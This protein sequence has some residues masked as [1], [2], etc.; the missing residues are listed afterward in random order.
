MLAFYDE[1]VP[2]R[3][4]ISADNT[5]RDWSSARNVHFIGFYGFV[6]FVYS[7]IRL[8]CQTLLLAPQRDFPRI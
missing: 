2:R 5:V 7:S 1:P 8:K 3:H 4:E 6:F